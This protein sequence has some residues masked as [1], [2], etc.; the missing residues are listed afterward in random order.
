MV[1]RPKG[2]GHV[3][4]CAGEGQ[5]QQLKTTDPSSRQR[6]RPT[7]TNPELSNKNL[8]VTPDGCF[9]PRQTGRLTVGRNIRL[10]LTSSAVS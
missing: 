10:R 8:A 6:E 2:L 5:Q 7:T 4:D 3:N 1:T 9:I